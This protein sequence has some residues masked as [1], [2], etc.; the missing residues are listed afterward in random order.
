LAAGFRPDLLGGNSALPR[1]PIRNRG[2]SSI[3]KGK[4]GRRKERG[5]RREEDKREGRVKKGKIF[6]YSLPSFGPGADPGIQAVSP[7]VS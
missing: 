5:T 2:R 7:Q 6:P 1:P 3:C 4:E